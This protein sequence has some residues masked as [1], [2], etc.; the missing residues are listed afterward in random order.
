VH[1][2]ELL[3]ALEG[4]F[5]ESMWAAIFPS[6]AD[7][8]KFATKSGLHIVC[9]QRKRPLAEQTYLAL[10]FGYIYFAVGRFVLVKSHGGLT[11]VAVAMV[12]TAM[13]KGTAGG[14]ASIVGLDTTITAVEIIPFIVA[15]VGLDTMTGIAKSVVATT[16]NSPVCFRIAKG[17]ARAG[18]PMTQSLAGVSLVL[19]V[20]TFSRIGRFVLLFFLN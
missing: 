8:T 18:I 16:G 1:S 9:P 2:N 11:F 4:P 15:A 20:A 17:L 7:V 6:S 12:F 19:L 10:V 5:L 13:R 14:L 3:A